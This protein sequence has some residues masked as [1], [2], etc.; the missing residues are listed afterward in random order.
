MEVWDLNV[1]TIQREDVT[2]RKMDPVLQR[3]GIVSL[4]AVSALLSSRI[5]KKI[6]VRTLLTRLIIPGIQI[7]SHTNKY[8]VFIYP[9]RV[10]K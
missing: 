10:F 2:C 1:Q 6:P 8:E 3:G 5:R 9:K 4:R 7:P